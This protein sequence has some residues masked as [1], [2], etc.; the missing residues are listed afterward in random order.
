MLFEVFFMA[1]N[2]DYCCD[3]KNRTH[4][5][6]LLHKN[7]NGTHS[8]GDCIHTPGL[9]SI[10]RGESYCRFAAENYLFHS[11]IENQYSR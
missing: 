7:Y 6:E 10:P 8:Y 1:R 2:C 4:I 5:F 9:P 3:A 11:S